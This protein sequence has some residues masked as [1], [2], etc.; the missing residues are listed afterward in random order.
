MRK[1]QAILS[2]ILSL[3]LAGC[4]PRAASQATGMA[5]GEKVVAPATIE[6]S[7][8]PE[9]ESPAI[10]K[11]PEEKQEQPLA[12]EKTSLPMEGLPQAV[13]AAME[14]LSQTLNTPVGEIGVV[15]YEQVQWRNGCLGFANP[16]EMCIDVITPGWQVIL[17][18]GGIQYEF[19]TND[20]GDQMRYREGP[21]APAGSR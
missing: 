12:G 20:H 9:E 1:A 17:D 10:G 19:H 6:R 8:A 15:I 18:A 7:A 21:R 5:T 2:I 16:N 11:T 13:R 4:A 3:A 14:R